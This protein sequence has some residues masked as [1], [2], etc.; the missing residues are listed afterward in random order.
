MTISGNIT[1]QKNDPPPPGRDRK[2]T[3][4]DVTSRVPVSQQDSILSNI[5]MITNRSDFNNVSRGDKEDETFITCCKCGLI[6]EWGKFIPITRSRIKRVNFIHIIFNYC[7]FPPTRNVG[8]GKKYL[9]PII[10]NC[11]Y[12]KYHYW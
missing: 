8:R 10:N 2:G 4:Y 1:P 5:Q 9:T 11:F 12:S 3:T 7:V 6:Y